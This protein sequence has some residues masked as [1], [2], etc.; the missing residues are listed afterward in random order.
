[1][2]NR[3]LVT[4]SLLALIGY[5]GLF[6]LFR[7][8][9]PAARWNFEMD[10]AAAIDR[11]KAAAASYG[12]VAPIQVESVQIEY[13]RADE[14][15][16][17]RQAEPLLNS[18]FTP[19]KA[20]VRLTDAKSGSS[21]E[22]RLNS[23]GEWLG[24]R[25]LEQPV[26]NDRAKDASQQAPAAD[27]LANDQRIADEA[28]KRFIGAGYGKFSFLSGSNAGAEERKFSWTASDEGM[29]VL[30]DVVVR[31]GKAREVWLQSNLT[32]KFQAESEARRGWAILALS[33]ANFLLILPTTILVI[34]LYVVSLA[35]RQIDHRKSLVFLACCFLL[36]LGVDLFGTLAGVLLYGDSLISR[37]GAGQLAGN[38]AKNLFVAALL[39]F[40][41]APG[42]ALASGAQRRGTVD[43]EL[44]L[45]GKLLRRPA[46][47]SL[48]A[49]L[50][51]GG[52]LAMIAH[53]I[54]A[55][56]IFDGAL[57]NAENM[58]DAF[59]APAPALNS[60]L[61]GSQIL[62][63]LSFAFLIPAAGAFV[64]RAWFQRI[65]AF[66][67]AFITAAGLEPLRTS[68]PAL[69][70][71]S[72]ILAYLLIWLYRNFG[73]LAVMIS[74]IA[75]SA[76]LNSA[77]LLAQPSIS[78]QASGRNVI[79]GLG[80]ALIA[81]LVGLWRSSEP[82]EE[83]M[84]VK[85][86]GENPVERERLQ[87]EFGVA[88]RAQLRMLPDSPPSVP[89]IDISA[90]C[91]PSKDVGGDLYDF[92]ALPGGKVGVVVA[93]VSG[94]GVPASLYMTLTKGL[95]DSIAEYKTDPGEILREINRH[96]YDVCRR[97][98]FVTMFLGVVDPIRRTLS[99]A[100]A[101]HNPTI[102]Y[103]NRDASERKTWML[104]SRGMG[105]GFNQG[106]IFDQSLKVETI[107]LERG[108][109]LFFY[110]DG[111]TEAMNEKRDEYGEGRLMAMAERTNG[112]SAEHSRNAVM[113]DVAE[114]LGPVYP[115]DDQTLVVLQIL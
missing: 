3:R 6:F 36:L 114:F 96:L 77:A 49:G 71:A 41:L 104:K 40:L 95:L 67:I 61:S 19:L 33:G 24:Y 86:P 32:P 27:A 21:F 65:L 54:V 107:Q 30:A 55:I 1:M 58:E 37:A 74:A 29:K 103:R 7:K 101:G 11:V 83:E 85:K 43:L 66:V 64:K 109:K 106:G 31:D 53:A 57:I 59:I 99:Y 15:Y 20:R 112:L 60:F 73:L 2:T 97:K 52:M 90:V 102:V 51:A 4:L 28:L 79:I 39:Y 42:L 69:I 44:L 5:G 45:K 13:H 88:R 12:Y 72:L 14:Y 22:A 8:T 25:L 18:I 93:D 10:R 34:I 48:V 62:I 46:T 111:I 68:A 76:A 84:A 115:Q 80:V 17:S 70:V 100:R 35:R 38:V 113:A 89:G 9:S 16:I 110:S 75:S 105:M 98:T 91:H 94:K 82:T 26:K 108:D 47:G 63:F 87:A 56:G 23:R 92:L 50:L 78:L 81:A